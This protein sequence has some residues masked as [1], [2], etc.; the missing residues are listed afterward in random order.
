MGVVIGLGAAAAGVVGAGGFAAGAVA[1]YTS[2]Y[3]V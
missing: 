2:T 1:I 3:M